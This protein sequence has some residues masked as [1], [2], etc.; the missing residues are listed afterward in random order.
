MEHGEELFVGVRGGDETLFDFS[1]VFVGCG[2]LL[3]F[4]VLNLGN[5]T[6]GRGLRLHLDAVSG[7][8][9]QVESLKKV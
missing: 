2:E 9:E 3:R 1:D 6:V 4:L 5:G 8:K 7:G